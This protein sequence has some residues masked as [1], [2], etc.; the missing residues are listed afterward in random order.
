MND[1]ENNPFFEHCHS[2]CTERQSDDV[3]GCQHLRIY[4]AV[5]PADGIH[6]PMPQQQPAL[7]DKEDFRKLTVS[8]DPQLAVVQWACRTVPLPPTA[9]RDLTSWA[10]FVEAA[11]GM[12]VMFDD[13]P[14][15]LSDAL[16]EKKFYEL[17]MRPI[18]RPFG[19][20]ELAELIDE[21]EKIDPTTA[22]CD[23]SY[24]EHCDPYCIGNVPHV[25]IG[26]ESF[27]KASGD[28]WVWFGDLPEKTERALWNAHARTLAFPAGLDERI[29]EIRAR[30]NEAAQSHTFAVIRF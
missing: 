13:L 18:Q 3:A 24:A 17:T 10:F 27:V 16:L 8:I 26:R 11:P 23:W 9:W 29:A 5:D 1:S 28:R 4:T 22:V 15:E 6:R 7:F 25:Q 14:T 2:R 21:I 30:A 19:A 20:E 12:W